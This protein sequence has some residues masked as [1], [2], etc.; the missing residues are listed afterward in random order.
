MGEVISDFFVVY[1]TYANNILK[2][3]STH[4]T[5]LPM[6]EDDIFVSNT[7]QLGE[8]YTDLVF[9]A[10]NVVFVPILYDDG[11]YLP[12]WEFA[13]SFHEWVEKYV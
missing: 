9:K 13:M 1:D 10:R 6:T 3:C 5:W 4:S 11:K 7:A 8:R 12:D 2:W